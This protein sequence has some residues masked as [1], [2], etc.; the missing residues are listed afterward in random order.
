MGLLGIPSSRKRDVGHYKSAR[1]SAVAP[2]RLKTVGKKIPEMMESSKPDCLVT[3]TIAQ[4]Q[5]S[6]EH[7]PLMLSSRSETNISIIPF[8]I[9]IFS[10]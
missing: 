10:S 4:P 3:R 9:Q 7:V 5:S 1:I 6:P 2:S 8:H